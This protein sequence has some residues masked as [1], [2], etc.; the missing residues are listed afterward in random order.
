MLGVGRFATALTVTAVAV[1]PS[2]AA[3]SSAVDAKRSVGTR[4]SARVTARST[5]SGTSGRTTRTGVGDVLNRFAMIAWAIGTG[6]RRL[7]GQ[8]L[9]QHHA[10]CVDV[11]PDVDSLPGGLLRAHVGRRAE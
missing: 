2:S 5:C 1:S 9:V 8:H 11:G 3:A 10:E 7:A 6:E 4:A